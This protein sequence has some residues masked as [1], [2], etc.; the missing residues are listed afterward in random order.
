MRHGWDLGRR[1]RELGVGK[2]EP[3]QHEA[4]NLF[5]LLLTLLQNSTGIGA[6]CSGRPGDDVSLSTM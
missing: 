4:W 3:F 2:G 6:A 1:I 5:L